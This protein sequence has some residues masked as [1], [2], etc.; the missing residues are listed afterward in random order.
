MSTNI[1][2]FD[3]AYIGKVDEYLKTRSD[4]FYEFHK[5]R[6]VK[7]DSYEERVRVKLPSIEDFAEYLG[8]ARKTLYNWEKEFK[9]FAAA[10]DKI[11]TKQHNL[12]IN[13]SLSGYYNPVISKLILTT[14]HGYRDRVDATS[15]DQPLNSFSDDQIDKIARRI[16]GRKRSIGDTPGKNK[17]D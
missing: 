17:S 15:K 1:S 6:G 8:V 5:V 16:T 12:I 2:T 14:N 7:S 3:P 9:E 10:L 11:R 13:G 4:E